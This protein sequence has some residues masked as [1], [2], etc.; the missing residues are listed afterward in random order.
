MSHSSVQRLWHANDLKPHQTKVFKVS[1]DPCFEEKFWDVIGLYMNPPD[2]ALVLCCDE[3]SQC[4][5]LERTQRA[6]P[7]TNG[8]GNRFAI[9]IQ[10][11]PIDLLSGLLSLDIRGAECSFWNSGLQTSSII[12]IDADYLT[13]GPTALKIAKTAKIPFP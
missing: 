2:R 12:D 13:P 9:S 1:N 5:A 7:L 11:H 10:Y 6:L 8:H 3:K 4:Q